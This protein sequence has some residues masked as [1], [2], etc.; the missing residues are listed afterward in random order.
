M[1]ELYLKYRCIL[2]THLHE[3]KLVSYVSWCFKPSQPQGIQNKAIRYWQQALKKHSAKGNRE[4]DK[5]DKVEASWQTVAIHSCSSGRRTPAGKPG[6]NHDPLFFDN[7][8]DATRVS[9][10]MPEFPEGLLN[11][12]SSLISP[13]F[14]PATAAFL[15]PV[16]FLCSSPVG[17]PLPVV[18]KK[19][20]EEW[21][22]AR[23]TLFRNEGR[24]GWYYLHDPKME[25]CRRHFISSGNGFSFEESKLVV[26]MFL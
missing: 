4:R 11:K 13:V 25:E 5:L 17:P 2:A 6:T 16:H 22:P 1:S 12:I 23:D 20:K 26:D 9:R 3:T 14:M 24:Q 7:A 18:T 19:M 15:H 10:E 8:S 21:P